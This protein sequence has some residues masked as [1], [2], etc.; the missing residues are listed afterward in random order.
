VLIAEQ[1]DAG[2]QSS[3][4]LPRTLMGRDADNGRP[5]IFL[6]PMQDSSSGSRLIPGPVFLRLPGLVDGCHRPFIAAGPEAVL[7]RAGAPD[8]LSG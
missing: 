8:D 1:G 6:N 5:C 4:N 2:S 7:H 3:R